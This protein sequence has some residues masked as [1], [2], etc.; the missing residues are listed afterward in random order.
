MV[1]T[2]SD[3]VG[4]DESFPVVVGTGNSKREFTLRRDSFIPRSEFFENAQSKSWNKDLQ[5]R[6][7]EPIVLANTSPAVFKS[8]ARCVYFGET[9]KAPE[10]KNLYDYLHGVSRKARF[11]RQIGLYLLAHKLGDRKTAN[12]MTDEIFT[13]GHV[14]LDQ[15]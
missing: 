5:C 7:D 6:S 9:P 4:P 10:Y 8:Y 14:S 13:Y 2:F 11:D 3:P 1:E 15:P 12:L